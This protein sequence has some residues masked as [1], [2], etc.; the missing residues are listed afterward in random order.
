MMELLAPGRK[1]RSRR[2]TH[3]Q[4]EWGWGQFIFEAPDFPGAD[5]N[6]L[7]EEIAAAYDAGALEGDTLDLA[8]RI[9]CALRTSL[10]MLEALRINLQADGREMVAKVRRLA[11]VVP[12]VQTLAN[13]V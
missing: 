1:A 11:A 4:I 5:R 7:V 2:F 12:A 8:A 13:W 9:G 6:R 10:P 3:E